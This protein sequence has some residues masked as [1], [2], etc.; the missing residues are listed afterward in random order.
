M[1]LFGKELFDFKKEPTVMYDFAQFGILNNREA[2]ELVAYSDEPVPAGYAEEQL[3]K[4][5][6]RRQEEKDTTISP[7]ELYKMSAL[8][9][10]KF[11]INVKEDYLS[12]Q[13]SIAKQKLELLGK[14][15]KTKRNDGLQFLGE[16]GYV[17]YGRES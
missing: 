11:G 7:R 2:F 5:A 17:K 1:K 15:P 12:E 4:A 10:N 6:K 16:A 14:A 3:K 9:D 13:I 8:N